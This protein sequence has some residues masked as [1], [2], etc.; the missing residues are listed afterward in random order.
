M[1]KKISILFLVII[2]FFIF[3]TQSFASINAWG[4]EFPDFPEGWEEAEYKII[5]L[6]E[7]QN[8]FDLLFWSGDEGY[9]SIENKYN[10]PSLV[11]PPGFSRYTWYPEN[12]SNWVVNNSDD[13]SKEFYFQQ[14]ASEGYV[15]S[16]A[17]DMVYSNFTIKN[18]DTDED[19]FYQTPLTTFSNWQ[20]TIGGTV[21]QTAVK[22]IVLTLVVVVSY[23]GLRK[24]WQTLSTLL[25]R[26]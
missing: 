13:K 16:G 19:F 18:I 2:L 5:V 10:S 7:A 26:A 22:V 14:W 20:S 17:K 12:T 3:S 11:I 25:H 1:T 15:G 21:W 9:F 4:K 6:Y 24:G 23:L 8:R